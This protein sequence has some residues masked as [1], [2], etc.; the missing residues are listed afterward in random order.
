[1]AD[2]LS[3]I[4]SGDLPAVQQAIADGVNVN[5]KIRNVRPL[6]AALG[7]PIQTEI[8]KLLINSGADA[9]KVTQSLCAV[10][11]TGDPVLVK[12]LLDAGADPNMDTPAGLALD[13][14]I[15]AKS[16]EIVRL[17]VQAGAQSLH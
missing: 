13:W 15:Q 5:K 12:A 6:E 14:A 4:Q 16:P 9:S 1:M 8:A 2:F 17:L 10:I 11:A 3:S 7:R